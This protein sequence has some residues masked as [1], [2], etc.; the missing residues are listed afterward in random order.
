MEKPEHLGPMA[1]SLVETFAGLTLPQQRR[2]FALLRETLETNE[3]LAE[4]G[5]AA[6]VSDVRPG[7]DLSTGDRET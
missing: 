4:Q 7:S 3:R 5:Q 2:V 6:T 1:R